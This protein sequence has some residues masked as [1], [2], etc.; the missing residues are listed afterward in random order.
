METYLELRIKSQY[1]HEINGQMITIFFF[2]FF[3]FFIFLSLASR[4]NIALFVSVG[5]IL[6]GKDIRTPSV[7]ST[8]DYAY[9]RVDFQAIFH[10]S[11]SYQ[12]SQ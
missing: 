4:T 6:M 12:I 2:F 7:S 5:I 10:L 8:N 1:F 9:I 3:F 11:L